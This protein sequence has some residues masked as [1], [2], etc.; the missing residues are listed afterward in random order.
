MAELHVFGEIESAENF[1][2]IALLCKWNFHAGN[3]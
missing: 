1:G 2:D 3:N